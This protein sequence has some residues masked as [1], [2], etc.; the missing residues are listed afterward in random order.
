MQYSET[1]AYCSGEPTN[2]QPQGAVV[3]SGHIQGQSMSRDPSNNSSVSSGSYGSAYGG[4]LSPQ[5]PEGLIMSSF[6]TCEQTDPNEYMDYGFQDYYTDDNS[7]PP[8]Y[9]IEDDSYILSP[10]TGTME[11]AYRDDV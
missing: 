3:A 7:V 10:G 9:P 1:Y 5:T 11:E 4:N 8:Y 6:Y 2:K